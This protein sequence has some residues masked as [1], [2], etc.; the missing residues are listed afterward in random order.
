MKNKI[1]GVWFLAIFLFLFFDNALPAKAIDEVIVSLRIEG[2]NS[3]MANMLELSLPEQCSVIPSG[4]NTPRLFTGYKAVCALEQAK[5]LGIISD[6][7]ITDWGFGFSLDSINYVTNTADWSESWVIRI[8][9]TLAMAGI[10]GL[11]LNAGDGLLL[12]YGPWPAEPAD[13]TARMVVRFKDQLLFDN[14]VTIP[15]STLFN[16]IDVDDNSTST[17]ST[18]ST[19]LAALLQADVAGEL[20]NVSDIY[21]YSSFKSF[22]VKCLQITT[23]TAFS[24]CDSWQYVVDGEYPTQGLDSYTINGGEQIYFYFGDRYSLD[25]DKVQYNLGEY[26]TG[27]LREYDF[28]NGIYGGSFGKTLAVLNE[29]DVVIS[30]S[31][32]DING[33]CVFTIS[34]TG[35]YKI[36]LENVSAWGS[37]YWPAVNFDVVSSASSSAE[38]QTQPEGNA[39][40]GGGGEANGGENAIN[41]IFDT[42]KAVEFLVGN[43]NADGS[44][45]S[46]LYTDWAGIALAAFN[47]D[48]PAKEKL[49]QYLISDPSVAAGL[50]PLSDYERRAMALMSLEVNPYSGTATN[51]IQKI[52]DG[53]DGNQFGEADLFNDDIFALFPLLKSG[54]TV[55]D[56]MIVSATKFIL[57][58]QESDGSW[59][60]V[61]LTAAAIQALS[62]VSNIEGVDNA[63]S[64]A[65]VYLHEQQR[66]DGGFGDSFGTAWALQAIS[67]IGETEEMWTV[68]GKKSSDFLYSKQMFDGGLEDSSVNTS[69]RVWATSYAVP[70][71]L[72]KPWFSILN[73]FEKEITAPVNSNIQPAVNSNIQ[74]ARDFPYMEDKYSVVSTTPA[75]LVLETPTTVGL[76]MN[77]PAGAAIS[78]SGDSFVN[79]SQDIYPAVFSQRTSASGAAK[80]GTVSSTPSVLGVKV[81]KEAA[82]SPVEYD[83]RHN[84]RR[85][86][87]ISGGGVL[88]LSVYLGLKFLSGYLRS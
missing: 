13:P 61:D 29:S 42:D 58:R 83:T 15:S 53:Y 27:T 81:E 5:S 80:S 50:N 86:L 22:L 9:N 57:S 59:G 4:S 75:L 60:G 55:S 6:F 37:Y 85:V 1:N 11:I 10:D 52:I 34:A 56:P 35:T 88:L 47:Q 18:A 68:N 14:M 44:F 20:F 7:Q 16:Y 32:T 39:S 33:Q 2:P 12:S 19:V 78:L 62:L 63:I 28:Q 46:S 30:T 25:L 73:N 72:R 76:A 79:F 43:Q 71:V 66:N 36:G 51:Y 69:T 17:T 65:K 26:A 45:Q 3:A 38:T 70:A 23:S 21:F 77:V 31:T 48:I 82:V 40:G 84:A 24:A 64:N 49:K 54:Y 87:A 74:S 67:A 8:N 41:N